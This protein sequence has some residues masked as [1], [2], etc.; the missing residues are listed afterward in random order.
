M[1]VITTAELDP[2]CRQPTSVETDTARSQT[3]VHRHLVCMRHPQRAQLGKDG[4]R[5][6]VGVAP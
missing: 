2:R 1:C 3:G 5:A 4:A 6:P